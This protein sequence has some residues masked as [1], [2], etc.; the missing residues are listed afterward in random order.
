MQ[1]KTM[2]RVGILVSLMLWATAG[3]AALNCDDIQASLAGKAVG[4]LCFHSDDLTTN[5]A[6]TTP[7]NNSITT[8]ADGTPCR[9]CWQ[10][11]APLPR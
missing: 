11:R 8:F 3:T 2:T 4:I 10:A 7:G 9:D 1:G 5:N 6:L